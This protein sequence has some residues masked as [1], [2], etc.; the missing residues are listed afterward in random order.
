MYE[1]WAK[2]AESYWLLRVG[3][4][5]FN[6]SSISVQRCYLEEE[7]LPLNSEIGAPGSCLLPDCSAV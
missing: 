2:A 4:S 3:L 7:L 5:L 6:V 1:W